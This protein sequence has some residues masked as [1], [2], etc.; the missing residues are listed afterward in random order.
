MFIDDE[1]IWNLF[2]KIACE[3]I[4]IVGGDTFH[5]ITHRALSRREPLANLTDEEFE[6]LVAKTSGR[7]LL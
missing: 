7:I 1:P 5:D 2:I 6:T 4:R 3:K